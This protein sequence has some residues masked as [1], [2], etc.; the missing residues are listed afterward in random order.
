MHQR[1][2]VV[3]YLR[4][5]TCFKCQFAC[6]YRNISSGGFKENHSIQLI[7]F[8]LVTLKILQKVHSYNV[9]RIYCDSM[10]SFFYIFFKEGYEME[11][12][13]WNSGCS[14]SSL[15][16]TVKY[17][18]TFLPIAYISNKI[19]LKNTFNMTTKSH[20]NQR[21]KNSKIRNQHHVPTTQF[22]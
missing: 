4:S 1:P 3:H 6:A 22:L 9:F 17:T 20:F 12:K 10:I 7:H 15:W 13:R 2:E 8:Q 16:T 14:K 11:C 18:L 19:L 21:L 5:L